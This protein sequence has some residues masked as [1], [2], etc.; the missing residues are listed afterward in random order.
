MQTLVVDLTVH[1]VPKVA[2]QR[3]GGRIPRH[4]VRVRFRATS[5][6]ERLGGIVENVQGV[7]CVSTKYAAD[8]MEEQQVQ[9]GERRDRAQMVINMKTKEN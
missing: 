8:A 2:T 9:R 4:R 1:A 6:I 7:D 5:L 3:P